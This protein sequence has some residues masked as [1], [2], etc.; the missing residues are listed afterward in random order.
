MRNEI[1]VIGNLGQED[2]PN[3]QTMRT[4]TV[5]ESVCEHY[6]ESIDVRFIDIRGFRIINVLLKWRMIVKSA[7]V[8]VLP[9]RRAIVP[10]ISAL[11]VLQASNKTVHVAIGGWLPDCI[12]ENGDLLEREK[13]L[14]AVLVQTMAVRGE[15]QKR[16]MENT[17]WFPNY[18]RSDTKRI[19]EKDACKPPRRFVFYSRVIEEKGVYY[20]IDAIKRLLDEGEDV[21]LDIFGPT[22]ESVERRIEEET[23]GYNSINYMGVLY[24]NEI[25]DTLSEYDCL[26]FPTYYR[27]EG[28]P[29]AVLEAMMAGVPVI[30]SDWKYIREIVEDE[31]N[32]LICAVHSAE[33]V[34]QSITRIRE[35]LSLYQRI[36]RGTFLERDK[37]T[38]EN[39]TP[40]LYE[41]IGLGIPEHGDQQ[42]E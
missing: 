2:K 8:I 10:V 16:G 40:I 18:R 14:K 34:Y 3:G 33:S 30:A 32:G 27:G 11:S 7:R 39:V 1:I 38:E 35:D 42:G 12:D 26:L 17:V 24:G 22:D 9:G 15:L 23:L 21:A 6:G 28:F 25:L 37:Y 5:F 4:K 20:A 29:G 36:C 19:R 31:V 13:E 41:A